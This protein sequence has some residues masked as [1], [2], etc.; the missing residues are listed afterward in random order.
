MLNI[1]IKALFWIIGKIGDIVLAPILLLINTLL[2]D[3]NI[4]I[5]AIFSYLEQGFQYIPFF[6]KV[7]MIPA[8]LIQLVIII[9]TTIVSIIVGLRVY[10]FIL[11]IYTKFKP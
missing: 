11:K 2:P 5:N 10:R 6:L 3:L 4:N 7:F 8:S 1:I 9:F